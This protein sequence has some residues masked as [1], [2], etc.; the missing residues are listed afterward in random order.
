MVPQ[1]TKLIFGISEW[2]IFWT[3]AYSAT[4]SIVPDALMRTSSTFC[5]TLERMGA[6]V[7]FLVPSH[8]AALIPPMEGAV[9]DGKLGPL[10]TLRHVVCCGEALPLST[11]KLFHRS[12]LDAALLALA[13]GAGV[14]PAC[15]LHNLYGPTE[16]S[17]TSFTCPAATTSVLIGKP[18]GN[19]VVLLVDAEMRPVPLGVVGEIL[20]GGC[21]AQG[22]LNDEAL[23]AQK[24]VP[25]SGLMP[26]GEGG[27]PKCPTF[28]RTG[29]TAVRLPSGELAFCGRIDRQCKVRGYRIELEAV[30]AALKD[31]PP[32]RSGGRIA[33]VP[34]GAGADTKLVVF[35]EASPGPERDAFEGLLDFARS[36]IP[37]YMVP[38]RVEALEMLPTLASGKNDLKMLAGGSVVG[39]VVDTNDGSHK[40]GGGVPVDSLGAVQAASTSVR[41]PE[42]AR[43]E[44]IVLNLLRALLMLGVNLDHFGECNGRICEVIVGWK[45]SAPGWAALGHGS[46]NL[47]DGRGCQMCT[48]AACTVA[49]NLFRVFGNWKAMS[50]FAMVTAYADS[51]FADAQRF[52][53]KDLVIVLLVLLWVWVL[54]PLMWFVAPDALCPLV[55]KEWRDSYYKDTP[56]EGTNCGIF[57]WSGP[58]WYLHFLI[59][60][61]FLV[62]GLRGAPPLL[63]CVL[64]L[65]VFLMMPPYLLCVTEST[66]ANE[67]QGLESF[68]VQLRPWTWG[69]WKVLITGPEYGG[70]PWDEFRY[71]VSRSYLFLSVQFFCTLHYGRPAVRWCRN[72]WRLLVEGAGPKVRV[73]LRGAAVLLS[74]L[75]LLLVEILTDSDELQHGSTY[76]SNILY[77]ATVGSWGEGSKRLT[78][79]WAAM[80]ALVSLTA[81]VC[82]LAFACAVGAPAT[83][84]RFVRLAGSTT[85]GS[86]VGST[87]VR[88]HVQ[89]YWYGLLPQ[90][91]PASSAQTLGGFA[92]LLLSGMLL[93]LTLFPLVHWLLLGIIK[94]MLRFAATLHRFGNALW[95]ACSAICPACL[96]RRFAPPIFGLALL[97]WLFAQPLPFTRPVSPAGGFATAS[98][99]TASTSAGSPPPDAE[100]D[101]YNDSSDIVVI[102]C[103][104]ISVSVY[105]C[106]AAFVVY[107]SPIWR[108]GKKKAEPQGAAAPPPAADKTRWE[109][110][111]P[112]LR[113]STFTGLPNQ[114]PAKAYYRAILPLAG[115]PVLGMILLSIGM[116]LSAASCDD[117][118]ALILHPF[119]P[120]PAVVNGER[121]PFEAL[122]VEISYAVLIL[123]VLL[124]RVSQ[125]PIIFHRLYKGTLPTPQGTCNTMPGLLPPKRP[126]EHVVLLPSYKEPVEVLTRTIESLAW[127]TIGSE[128][129]TVLIAME[130]RDANHEAQFQELKALFRPRFKSM[131]MTAHMLAPGELAGKAS[132][133]NYAVRELYRKHMHDLD[134]YTVLITI[135]DSDSI[136]SPRYFEQLNWVYSQQP[137]PHRLMYHPV[138][139]TRRN[140]FDANLVIGAH[141]SALS[142]TKLLASSSHGGLHKVA[143]SNYSLTLGFARDIEFWSVDNMPED[144]HTSVKAYVISNGCDVLVPV[145]AVIS[146]DL[147]TDMTDRYIQAKRHAWGVTEVAYVASLYQYIRFPTWS[148]LLAARIQAELNIVPGWLMLLL[149]GTW[150]FLSAVQPM[151]LFFLIG[152]AVYLSTVEY[153]TCVCIEYFFWTV[154]LP[155]LAPHVPE[156]T[157]AQKARLVFMN[158]P[159]VWNVLRVAGSAYFHVIA[160]WHAALLSC[161]QSEIKYL[162]APKGAASPRATARVRMRK[163]TFGQSLGGAGLV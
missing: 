138:F 136:F 26:H 3:L 27:V 69:V 12:V 75:L 23:T 63:Q 121:S 93:Q 53:Q 61:K 81:L 28:F 159:I 154:L 34:Q 44:A 130:A 47:G 32:L 9:Q 119:R 85:L 6:S 100:A 143:M 95:Q 99:T 145:Y 51:A 104:A 60:N 133:E 67:A 45:G 82:L 36:H 129:L 125:L 163:R 114:Q 132:N 117:H 25:N 52:S 35:V 19:T 10:R 160:R 92:W 155:P 78:A 140:Y 79:Q 54:D 37:E 18:I 43:R 137:S 33:C 142:C 96:I 88:S 89:Y 120:A 118:V 153:A 106:F 49:N 31:F 150:Q 86:Y 151:T 41:S 108:D 74:L 156:P 46:L 55:D 113:P 16:G 64:V 123:F 124:R 98:S 42:D 109:N 7:A 38:S 30:E 87:Y 97:V 11:V 161:R 59:V 66:C 139:D 94:R 110:E 20:F 122:V 83:E 17:M 105:C 65:L 149:P 48:T 101:T 13:E 39:D 158:L 152:F 131:I 68:W 14:A 102:A 5:D 111:W 4:L 62:V 77:L 134:P 40:G 58:R 22:Y 1:K 80:R 8:L 116:P 73:A 72:V 76:T 128:Q 148:R 144:A 90:S 126:R 127:Q 147:V 107:L 24:F 162:T 112:V 21:V 29:D 57:A 135:A 56:Y 70:P 146:N 2:E 141:E 115:L 91:G 15:E 103:M 71:I 50:G 157:A 84:S